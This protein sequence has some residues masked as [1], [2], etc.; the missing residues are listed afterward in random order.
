MV[1]FSARTISLYYQTTGMIVIGLT[2]WAIIKNQW[3]T[4][5]VMDLAF[6]GCLELAR[7]LHKR[8]SKP[9]IEGSDGQPTT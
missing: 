7:W 1:R 2:V 8:N 6:L 5:I 3:D 9:F 4:G